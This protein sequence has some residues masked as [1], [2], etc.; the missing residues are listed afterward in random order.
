MPQSLT[1]VIVHVIFS[2]KDEFRMFL[3]K[4]GVE[5]EEAYVWD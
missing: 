3:R 2:T 1:L 4:Y 5:Y